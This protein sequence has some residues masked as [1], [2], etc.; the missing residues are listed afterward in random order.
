MLCVGSL[1]PVE[2]GQ[3]LIHAG[4]LVDTAAGE[5]TENVDILVDGNRVREVGPDLEVP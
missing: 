3:V 1:P 4:R 2:A 5:V